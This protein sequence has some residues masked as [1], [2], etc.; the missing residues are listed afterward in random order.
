MRM[1]EAFHRAMGVAFAVGQS[2]VF[3][4][5]CHPLDWRRLYRHA[6]QD[7]QNKLHGGMRSK[8]AVGQHAMKSN[9]HAECGESVH[10]Y[11]EYQVGQE[12]CAL[13]KRAYCQDSAEE[14]TGNNDED[15]S[16]VISCGSHKTSSLVSTLAPFVAPIQ[17]LCRRGH[18]HQAAPRVQTADVPLLA[19]GSSHSAGLVPR[20]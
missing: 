16:F 14:R 11:Q 6:T 5:R 9:S 2:M 20:N 4:V 1:K 7:E 3:N 8:A 17:R 10:R 15:I 18:A 12:N 19:P 13:P